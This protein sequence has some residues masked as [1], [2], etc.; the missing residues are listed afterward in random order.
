MSDPPPNNPNSNT[1]PTNSGAPGQPPPPPQQIGAGAGAATQLPF[2]R[3][4]APLSPHMAQVQ[5]PMPPVHHQP[6]HPIQ[7][8]QMHPIHPQNPPQNPPQNQNQPQDGHTSRS[9]NVRDALEYL[10][11]VKDQFR[12]QPEVY[13]RFLDI[14]KDFKS[15][16]IDTPGVIDRVSTLFRGHPS[17]VTGFNTF[18]PPGY[19]IEATMNPLDPIRVWTPTGLQA[20][21][22]SQQQ[23]QS[24]T[25]PASGPPPVGQA[26]LQSQQQPP[27]Q[28]QS[29]PQQLQPGPQP[30]TSPAVPHYPIAPAGSAPPPQQ[31]FGGQ[32]PPQQHQMPIPNQTGPGYQNIPPSHLPPPSIPPPSQQSHPSQLAPVSHADQ[33]MPPV[34]KAPV[35]FSHAISYVN[36]IKTRFSNEQE[37][38]KQFLEILQ[39]YQRDNKPI[40]EVY[41]QVQ[42]LFSNAP[43]LL[44]EFKKFLPEVNDAINKRSAAAAGGLAAKGSAGG[45]GGPSGGGRMPPLGNFA[46]ADMRR[47]SGGNLAPMPAVGLGGMNGGNNN[48]RKPKRGGFGPSV[49]MASQQQQQQQQ[50]H[51]QVQY[52]GGYAGRGGSP[53]M[54]QMPGNGVMGSGPMGGPL[55]GGQPPMKRKK[56][57]ATS[58]GNVAPPAGYAGRP[59]AGGGYVP[60]G[61]VVPG[62]GTNASHFPGDAQPSAPPPPGNSYPHHLGPNGGN[63]EELEWID[64]CKR[65]IANKAVYNEFLKVLNLFSNEIIDSKTLVERVEPFLAKAPDLF[66]WFKKFVKYEEEQ[67]VY[68][69]A[70]NRPDVDWRTCRRVGYSYRRMPDNVPRSACSGRDDLCREVL[71]DDWVAQ[72][73]Y[74]SSETGGFISHKKTIYE[75]ALHKCE[76]E[77]YE[78]D[79]NIEA[80]QHTIAL[81]EPIY[82]RINTMSPEERAKFKLP[83]GLG[84]VSKTIYQ[85]VIKKIYDVEK[86]TE[87]IDA[88]HNNP[89]VAVPIV[90][91]RLKQ[92]DEEWKRCQRDWNKVWRE[93]DA[94]NYYKAL[95]HQGITFKVT[96][97]KALSS[98]TLLTEIETLY[99]E[100]RERRRTALPQRATPSAYYAFVSNSKLGPGPLTSTAFSRHQ[101]D[102]TLGDGIGSVFRDARRLVLM[103]VGTTTTVSQGE[104]DRFGDF[105]NNFLKRFFCLGG[106]EVV[107][108]DDGLEGSVIEDGATDGGDESQ[109][110]SRHTLR[111]EVLMKQTAL[112]AGDSSTASTNGAATADVDMLSDTESVSTKVTSTHVRAPIKREYFPFFCNSSLY[113]MFRLFEILCA[114]LAKLKELSDEYQTSPPSFMSVI[115]PTAV[116]LGLQ[117][118]DAV[119]NQTPKS[120]DRYAGLMRAVHELLESKIDAIEYEDR[121]RGLFGTTAYLGYTLDKVVSTLVKQIQVVMA[122]PLSNDLLELYLRDRSKHA[123]SAR[124]ENVYRLNAERLLD[125]DNLYRLDYHVAPKVLTMQLLTKEDAVLQDSTSVEELW[126]VYVDQF[127][128]LTG[129]SNGVGYNDPHAIQLPRRGHVTHFSSNNGPVF[130]SEPFLRRTLNVDMEHLPGGILNDAVES[131]SGLELKICLNTYKMFFVEDTED[132]F[133][134]RGMKKAARTGAS[135]AQAKEKLDA[136]IEERWAEIEVEDAAGEDVMDIAG[137]ADKVEETENV[138]PV[139][140]NSGPADTGM[141]VEM[142]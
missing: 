121:L 141:D 109:G 103:H 36:K 132:Y 122:D 105:F 17:L 114:R 129:N 42:I 137:D 30:R 108:D 74:T 102:F 94:K 83:V 44:E 22:L 128:Q 39:T 59:T 135:N 37:I 142:Q 98:K 62:P 56:Y 104:E 24:Q 65:S 133:A 70:A 33:A 52:P 111:K 87:M 67:V 31:Y 53:T 41:S 43:D 82:R 120:K 88:L 101:M 55:P 7:H 51:Q 79:M 19:R 90:L 13:N 136:W 107:S 46:S 112:A 86:G 54:M 57:D 26:P 64:R 116:N 138:D 99:R 78:F 134:R 75:E 40:L 92:K 71:N 18:L 8:Q 9:L 38:Y 85:R 16:S 15:Q 27:I 131:R 63:L 76:E 73:D 48:Q 110:F 3:Y 47:T 100:Q 93:I 68:N 58:A 130:G 84:G 96:D 66:T 89:A 50:Q 21:R 81:L 126:S 4:S 25:P 80:N 95:D 91:R 11:K 6:I 45:P 32:Q 115:N 124:Q 5:Q 123:S 49:G 117:Q 69:Y 113:V 125:D 2:P 97:R 10:D 72:A 127:I 60:G 119:E 14:M 139:A 20:P 35:E 28:Q 34:K 106:P 118:P 23:P 12:S 1:A 29:Q 61:P 140:V 77:R